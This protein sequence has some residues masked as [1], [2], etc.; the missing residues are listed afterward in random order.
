MKRAI[1][2]ALATLPLA[3]AAALPGE[4]LDPDKAFPAFVALTPAPAGAPHP[5]VDV[6]FQILDGYYLYRERFR[7]SIEGAGLALG[8]PRLPRGELKDDPFVGKTEILHRYALVHWPFASTPKPGEY[9][10]H[11]TAQG[12]LTDKV[13]YAPFTQSLRLRVP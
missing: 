6:S 2:A 8:E 12:C 4:P 3:A 5:G 1:L 10:L 9:T 7:I 11:V 13:C